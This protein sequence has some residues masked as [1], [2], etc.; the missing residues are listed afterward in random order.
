MGVVVGCV[1]AVLWEGTVGWVDTVACVV[2]EEEGT[3]D[4]VDA[5][6]WEDAVVWVEEL[7]SL[8]CSKAHP[9]K[10]TSKTMT[11]KSRILKIPTFLCVNFN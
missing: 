11:R 4:A 5:D 8:F 1:E 10:K 2:A 6:V 3:V 9:H 7:F